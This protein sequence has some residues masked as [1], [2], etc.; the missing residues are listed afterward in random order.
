MMGGI[1]IGGTPSGIPGPMLGMQQPMEIG[2]KP[3]GMMPGMQVPMQ[4]GMIQRPQ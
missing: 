3:G 1:G 4:R 2:G